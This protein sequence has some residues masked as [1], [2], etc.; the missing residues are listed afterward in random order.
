[1]NPHFS[2]FTL[3]LGILCVLAH[4]KILNDN[5]VPQFERIPM[6]VLDVKE[7]KAV[8]KHTYKN[9][10]ECWYECE[11]H[12]TIVSKNIFEKKRVESFA[13]SKYCPVFRGNKR[14]SLTDIKRGDRLSTYAYNPDTKVVDYIEVE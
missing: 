7:E 12:I 9:G 11:H 13:V 5:L 2:K 4:V 3:Y 8:V 6:S 1:M 10:S 14:T